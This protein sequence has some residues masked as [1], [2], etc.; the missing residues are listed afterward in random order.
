MKIL[1]GHSN[2][3]QLHSIETLNINKK[4]TK[5][6]YNALGSTKFLNRSYDIECIDVGIDNKCVNFSLGD[7]KYINMQYLKLFNCVLKTSS[8]Y[9]NKIW[10]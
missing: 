8:P 6:I 10:H 4:I 5:R 1:E 9:I 2:C 3:P 7:I